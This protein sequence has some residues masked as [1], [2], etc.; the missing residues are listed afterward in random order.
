[1]RQIQLY[2]AS[3]HQ[4]KISTGEMVER[5]HRLTPQ[6]QPQ[7]EAWQA[8]IR[9]S[10]AVPADETGWREDG[11]NGSIWS[12]STPSFRYDQYHHSRGHEVVEDLLGPDFEGGLGSDCSAAYKVYTGLHQRCWVHF[13]R[14]VHE[15]Q[16]KHPHDAPLWRWA[17]SVKAL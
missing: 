14:D 13:L 11:K 17:A 16:E 7:V 12:L 4:L 5:L 15:L 10:P 1:V 6:L 9:A 3:L 2:L 8:A